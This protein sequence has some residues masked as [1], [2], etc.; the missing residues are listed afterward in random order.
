M[1]GW[2]FPRMKP[3]DRVRFVD[4]PFAEKE[5]EVEAVAG[6]RVRVRVVLSDKPFTVETDR[7]HLKAA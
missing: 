5:A 1:F 3:G 6:G 4:G 7:R 2:L